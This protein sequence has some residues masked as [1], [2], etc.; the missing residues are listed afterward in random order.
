VNADLAVRSTAA[1]KGSRNRTDQGPFGRHFWMHKETRLAVK[2]HK[3][4]RRKE[5]KTRH[6]IIGLDEGRAVRSAL[7][8][9]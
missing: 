4:A 7:C 6:V 3:G 1:G 2:R 5:R 8:G 9:R